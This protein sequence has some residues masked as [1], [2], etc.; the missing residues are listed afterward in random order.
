MTKSYIL[1]SKNTNYSGKSFSLVL[2]TAKSPFGGTLHS[3]LPPPTITQ[4]CVG[5]GVDGWLLVLLGI[6]S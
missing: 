5:T 2:F 3:P 6:S 1:T 4:R